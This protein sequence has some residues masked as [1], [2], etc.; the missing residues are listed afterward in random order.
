MGGFPHESPTLH[1]TLLCTWKCSPDITAHQVGASS[2]CLRSCQI[3]C[4]P[5]HHSEKQLSQEAYLNFAKPVGPTESP[6][7]YLLA[8]AHLAER[9]APPH[10]PESGRK[11]FQTCCESHPISPARA[12]QGVVVMGCHTADGLQNARPIC[13]Y[14]AHFLFY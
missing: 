7:A 4:G 10:L 11:I 12:T 1:L 3:V 14:H 2:G 13:L 5:K 6:E 9:V 8:T